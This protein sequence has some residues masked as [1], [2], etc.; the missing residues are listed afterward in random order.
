MD[1][2]NIGVVGLGA[3]GTRFSRIVAECPRAELVA[4]ADVDRARAE[5][6]AKTWQVSAYEDADAM[7]DGETS[8]DALIIATSDNAH[9]A[10]ALA[11]A[12]AGK[13]LFVEKPL[14]MIQ[15]DCQAIIDEARKSDV[16][17]LVGQT[18]RFDPRYAAA[19]EAIQTGKIGELVH[20]YSRRNNPWNVV[21]RYGDRVSIAFFLG[22]H[23][24]DFLIWAVDAKV[25]RVFAEGRRGFLAGKGWD[26]DDTIFS[27]VTFDSGIVSCLENSWLV[28]IDAP[29][30]M[31]SHMFE[32]EG[33]EGEIHLVPEQTGL[34]IRGKGFCDHPNAVYNPEVAGHD[35]GTY[36][37][38]IEHFLDCITT[39]CPPLAP[40]EE[41]M[42]AVQVIEAVHVSLKSGQPVD[43]DI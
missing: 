31:Y 27:L 26:L 34:T 38:E 2:V 17:L 22:I 16:V 24:M 43:V 3:M 28:P 37:D 20:T 19:R 9:V 7:L 39:G 40:G 5:E 14:S 36:R 8:L 23:D 6:A 13:H 25:R 11:G 21:Q 12:Q 33:T 30:R 4:V 35:V 32:A 10:P 42:R 18:L 15:L 41:A 1:K 29:G